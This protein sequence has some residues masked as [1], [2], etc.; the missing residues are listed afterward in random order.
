MGNSEPCRIVG[1]SRSSGTRWRHGHEVVLKSGDIK[2]YPPISHQRPA[3]ISARFFSESERIT[4]ADLLHAGHSIRAIAMELGRSR[5]TVSREIRRNYRPR[6]AQRS[7]ER[8]SSRQ[9][10]GKLAG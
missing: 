10:T 2:K 5:W 8:R 7:A 1:I 9:R 6:T 3:V 4:I